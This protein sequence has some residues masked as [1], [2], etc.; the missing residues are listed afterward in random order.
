MARKTEEEKARERLIE[1]ARQQIREEL[2]G[3]T[4]GKSG[5]TGK[6]PKS[7]RSL[8]FDKRVI[9]GSML[10]GFIIGIAFIILIGNISANGL[11]GKKDITITTPDSVLDTGIVNNY[12]AA[13]FENAIL[14]E[15]MQKQELIV[16]EQYLKIPTTLSKAG[17]FN[18]PIFSQMKNVVYYGTGVYTID[19]SKLDTD[20]IDVDMENY[21]VSISIPHSCLQY[22]NPD[23][24]KTEFEDTEKGFLSFG[25][26]KLTTE[27]QNQVEQAAMNMMRDRLIQNELFT[28]ADN[29]ASNN[30][31]QL[32]QPIINT[33]SPDFSVVVMFDE[34]TNHEVTAK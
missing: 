32:F 34:T 16:M 2:E 4:S 21:I 11:F 29:F 14:G 8:N 15:A 9:I 25:D 10:L 20:S 27:E 18:F 6:K 22:I 17:L 1:E 33:V 31:W 23:I 3:K 12:T 7:R 28:K 26:I 30:V 24:N 19:L 5:R 13:D